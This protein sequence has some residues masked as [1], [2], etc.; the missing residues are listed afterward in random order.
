MDEGKELSKKLANWGGP[1]SL[2][3]RFQTPLFIAQGGKE[4]RSALRSEPE[5][6]ISFQFLEQ[7][8]EATKL[9]NRLV[10]LLNSEVLVPIYPEQFACTNT[11]SLAGVSVI[12][13]DDIEHCYNLQKIACGLYVY[14]TTGAVEPTIHAIASVAATQVDLTGDPIVG[15]IDASVAL[16]FP[17]VPCVL[18]KVEKKDVTDALSEIDLEFSEKETW[19]IHS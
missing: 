7:T 4:Q 5:R 19:Q 3:Y 17:A 11:G 2:R 16:F 9:F 8:L 10:A 15:A 12:T 1:V 6:G 14:D 13:S 18:E